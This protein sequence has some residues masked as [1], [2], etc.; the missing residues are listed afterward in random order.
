LVYHA[1]FKQLDE[2]QKPLSESQITDINS[3]F[4][5]PTFTK[6]LFTK[7]DEVKKD[8]ITPTLKINDTPQVPK[9]PFLHHLRSFLP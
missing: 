6:F 8:A 5:N 3:Y 2:D 7:N 4:K 9:K 1:Y